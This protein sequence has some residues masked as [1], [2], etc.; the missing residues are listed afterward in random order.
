[1]T[2]QS[3]GRDTRKPG[4]YN[5]VLAARRRLSLSLSCTL[6]LR[7]GTPGAAPP[8]PCRWQGAGGRGGSRGDPAGPAR[9]HSVHLQWSPAP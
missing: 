1:M 6:S 7:A 3:L 5:G 4:L 2:G 9:L 8:S